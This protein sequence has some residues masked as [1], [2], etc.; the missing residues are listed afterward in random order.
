ML[1]ACSHYRSFSEFLY[2][3]EA[4]HELGLVTLTTNGGDNCSMLFHGVYR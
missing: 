3:Y 4:G 1:N 2:Q